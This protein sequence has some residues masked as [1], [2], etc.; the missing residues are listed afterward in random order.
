MDFGPIDTVKFAEAMGARGL[1]V[2]RAEDFLPTL[3]LAMELPGPIV[4]DVAVDHSHNR[5]LGMQLHPQAL[6]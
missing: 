2:E 3:R 6:I 1:A 5:A 4:I